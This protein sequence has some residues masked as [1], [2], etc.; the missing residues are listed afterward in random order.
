M[1]RLTALWGIFVAVF[2]LLII[3]REDRLAAQGRVPLGRLRRLWLKPDRRRAPRYRVDWPVRYQRLPPSVMNHANSRDLSM[4]GVALVVPERLEVG[5]LIQ[6]E[7]TLPGQ[8]SPWIVTGQVMWGREVPSSKEQ[9]IFA[10][11]IQFQGL[12]A[13]MEV[14]LAAAL[15]TKT[16]TDSKS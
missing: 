8:P 2:I 11:G 1:F 5:S 3:L 12:D 6:V 16:G 7:L 13:Q 14:T 9:R 10:V 4:T 15:N